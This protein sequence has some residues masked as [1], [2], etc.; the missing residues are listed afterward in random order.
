MLVRSGND[1]AKSCVLILNK[2][3]LDQTLFSR[4]LRFCMY[5]IWIRVVRLHY[6]VVCIGHRP[7]ILMEKQVWRE[8]LPLIWNAKKSDYR[9]SFFNR[10]YIASCLDCR[11]ATKK[12]VLCLT[13]TYRSIWLEVRIDTN[14]DRIYGT[15]NCISNSSQLLNLVTCTVG[16]YTADG[17]FP[18]F[19]FILIY[20]HVSNLLLWSGSIFLTQTTRL[21]YLS[22]M[23]GTDLLLY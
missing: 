1:W 23:G 15:H 13:W 9:T 11:T 17:C 10:T 3:V 6:W 5:L 4:S 20:V 12:L 18:E 14:S 22:L 8:I 16:F 21:F 7:G 19:I 2:G